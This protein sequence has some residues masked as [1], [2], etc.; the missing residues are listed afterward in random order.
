[1]TAASKSGSARGP[2]ISLLLF[3]QYLFA[4]I[5]IIALGYC[6]HA[7]LTGRL[8]QINHA[9]TFAVPQTPTA[10]PGVSATPEPGPAPSEE[11]AAPAEGTPPAQLSVPRLGFSTVIVEGVEEADLKLGPGHIPG[12][13]LPGESGNVGV[14]GH[15]DSSFR[16]LRFIHKND[17][18]SLTSTHG[19]DAYRVV[20][21]EIVDPSDVQILYPTMDDE[22]TIITCYPFYYIGSA[23]KRFIIHADRVKAPQGTAIQES[24]VTGPPQNAGERRSE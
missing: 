12:T 3:A 7:Y 20:S 24:V 1:V 16:P 17:L 13:A 11:P 23:P 22:L 21:T 5:A 10:G 8:F 4:V 14:A 18:I 9:H 19:K 15:R 6:T 2:L